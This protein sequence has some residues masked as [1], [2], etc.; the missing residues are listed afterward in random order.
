MRWCKSSW[1]IEES[2]WKNPPGWT[3]PRLAAL[4]A[5]LKRK[6]KTNKIRII[7]SRLAFASLWNVFLTFHELLFVTFILVYICL[8]LCFTLLLRCIGWFST[9]EPLRSGSRGRVRTWPE[10]T[11]LLPARVERINPDDGQNEERNYCRIEKSVLRL[12]CRFTFIYWFIG[13]GRAF[14]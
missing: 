3:A 5:W 8:L 6:I 12:P 14:L 11:T 2:T 1:K 13:A 9:L 7:F 4:H 10:N